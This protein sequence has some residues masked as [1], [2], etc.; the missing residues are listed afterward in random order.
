MKPIVNNRYGCYKT[1]IKRITLISFLEKKVMLYENNL[2]HKKM[3]LASYQF[4]WEN[5]L[6]K[7]IP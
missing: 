1:K 2:T 3:F 6:F 5:F 4:L 7:S